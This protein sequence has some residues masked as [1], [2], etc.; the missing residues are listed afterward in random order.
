MS[1]LMGLDLGGG[2][3]RAVLVDSATGESHSSSV[4]WTHPAMPGSMGFEF[5]LD[6]TDIWNKIALAC[7]RVMKKAG[8]KPEDISGIATTS[9]RHGIVVIDETGNPLMATPAV[10]ARAAMESITLVVERGRELY[11]ITGR[12]PCP[13]FAACRLMW[14]K[15]SMPEAFSRAAAYLSVADW[16]GYKLT[17]AIAIEASLAAESM[18][19]DINK[20]EWSASLIDSYELPLSVFPKVVRSGE[21]I[22]TLNESVAQHLGLASGIPVS[23]GGSDT[24][25]GLLGSGVTAPGQLGIIA[26]TTVPMMMISEKPLIDPENRLWTGLGLSKGQYVLESNSGP[27]GTM[28]ELFA[29]IMSPERDN[30]A[31]IMMAEAA[32]AV[33][34][35]NGLVSTLGAQVFNGSD[36]GVPMGN[37][38]ISYM[39]LL[40]GSGRPDTARSIIEGMAFALR[41]N[42]ESIGRV[43]GSPPKEIRITGGLSH[44][45]VFTQ[46]V[47]DVMNT[48]IGVANPQATCIGSAIAAGVGAGVFKSLD[49]GAGKL[50]NLIREHSPSGSSAK[51]QGLYQGWKGILAPAKELDSVTGGIVLNAIMG[52]SETCETKTDLKFRPKIFISAEVDEE[53]LESLKALGDVE[54]ASYREARRLLTGDDL[55]KALSGVNIFIT[56]VDVVDAKS[57]AKLPDLRMIVVCRADPVNIDIKAAT[58]FGIPVVNTPG[59]NALAVADLATAYI[60]NLARKI[61]PADSFIR[62]PGGEAGDMGRMGKA[63]DAF[64][65]HE[66]AGLTIGLVGLGAVGKETAKRLKAFGANILAFDPYISA[67]KAIVAGAR[68]AE[69]DELLACSDIVSLHAPVTDGTRRMINADALNKMKDGTCLINTARAALVDYD[70]LLDALKSG[71]LAGAALDVFN[72]EPPAADDPL[73]SMPNVISTPHI[74]GNTVEVAAHQGAS[75]ANAVSALLKGGRPQCLLN[76][77]VLKEFSWTEKA[78]IPDADVLDK[79][80]KKPGASV[81]D[82]E[83][84]GKK[85]K[86][87]VSSCAAD[88]SGADEAVREH[89]L[90]IIKSFTSRIEADAELKIFAADKDVVMLFVMT[91]LGLPFYLLFREGEVKAEAV[92]PAEADVVLKMK[93]DILDGM[94]T[95]RVSGMDA[96]MSG[97]L[98][99]SGD[100]A[101][102]MT[103]Q[104]IQ[105]DMMRLYQEVR[106]EIG[107]PGDLT[108]IGKKDQAKPAAASQATAAFGAPAI[109]K[110]GDIRDDLL[111]VTNELYALGL[112]TATGGNLSVRIPD[113]PGELWITPSHIFKGDLQPEMMVRIDINGKPLDDDCGY[114]ASSE[115]HMHASIYRLR[116]DVKAVVHSHPPLATILDLSGTPFRPINTEVAFIADLPVVPFIMPGSK[117][118]ADAVAKAIGAGP[119]VMM[120]NHGL[121]VAA[122]SLRRAADMTEVLETTSKTLLA[123]RS[124]GVTPPEIPHEVV[125]KLRSLSDM[126]A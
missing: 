61:I 23:A 101:K 118:L 18:A 41:A 54:Y 42:I 76:P 117:E 77:E 55:V 56:E 30:A 106:T 65:G 94:F 123:C 48:G 15:T 114:P 16:I 53:S 111:Q 40:K 64:Q 75:A 25:C 31:E 45:G 66:L 93:A 8:A 87:A 124:L 39:S 73:V 81:T 69:L 2:S 11:E 47:S 99:F 91:D 112:I 80:I 95:G 4:A 10:D 102:A 86:Q 46:I 57:L 79:L 71:K 34:G 88:I 121:I 52:E 90:K 70:A 38:S 78:K 62:E 13:V 100:T 89:M 120:R 24:Q 125:E 72:V 104:Q 21:A 33:P 85:Q 12:W 97:K 49:E 27:M 107:D 59:R 20:R 63:H 17:G 43:A 60:L 92:E 37:L 122:V 9:M 22:G 5:D 119:A 110:V 113:K 29:K 83:A 67:E 74:G 26:G 36:L 84:G 7:R 50:V 44:S 68:K 51:Y 32:Q 126:M 1:Y 35:S 108:K 58:E 28:L 82:L 103:F 6:T 96:A 3:G 105:K 115:R 14:M 116:P 109:I 19:Y 98:S